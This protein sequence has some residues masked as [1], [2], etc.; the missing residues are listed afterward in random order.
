[1]QKEHAALNL[2]KYFVHLGDP[3]VDRTKGHELNGSG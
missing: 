3:R 1:M 2:D